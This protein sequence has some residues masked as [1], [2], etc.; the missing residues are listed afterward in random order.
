MTGSMKGSTRVTRTFVALA[1][2]ALPSLLYAQ[3]LPPPPTG[4]V[5][6]PAETAKIKWG[7]LFLQ[8]NF[9]VRNVG[10]DNN[11][12]NEPANPKTDWTA[13]AT[14][15]TLVGL[16]YGP[17]RF[18]V[19]TKSDYVYFAHYKSERAIDGNTRTQLELRTLRLRPWIGLERI[20]THERAGLEIDERAG[21]KLPAYDAGIEWRPGFRVATRL[22]FKR[23][24]VDY[25]EGEDFRGAVL[26]RALDATY[27]E[28]S[29]Q[30]L[31]EISPLSSFRAGAELTRARFNIATQRDSDDRAVFIGIE[32]RRDAALEGF[33]DVGWRERTPLA[34]GAPRFSGVVARASASFVLWDQVRVSFGADRDIA[35]SYEDAYAFYTQEGASTVVA[36]RPHDRLEFL[37][38]GR[39]YQLVYDNAVTSDAVLRTDETYSYGGG[40]GFFIRG[41]PGTRLGF[42]VERQV[43]DSVIADRRYDTARFYT[44]VGFSF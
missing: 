37:G 32:G 38:S 40:F 17:V 42:T 22:M 28:A 15:G 1:L 11:V 30:V 25:E 13:T 12:F 18:T 9:S 33:V 16:R 39:W 19:N 7:P 34:D 35:W 23:R 24:E 8:P 14:M 21:R 10:K 31:Y 20:K 43:R 44:N 4:P 6:D 27:E 29:L 36:W 3:V 26:E 5:E 2:L 41:Y